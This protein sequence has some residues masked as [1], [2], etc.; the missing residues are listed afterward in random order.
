MPKSAGHVEHGD[1]LVGA[2]AGAGAQGRTVRRVAG[3]RQQDV[4]VNVDDRRAG[5]AEVAPVGVV[6]AGDVVF[7]RGR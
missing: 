5:I 6:L 2:G 3:P 4:G 7:R 1:G